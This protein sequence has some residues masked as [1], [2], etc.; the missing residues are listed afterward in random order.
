M[1]KTAFFY[2]LFFTLCQSLFAQAPNWTV[3]E[4]D[5]QYTMT[6]VAKLNADGKQ[7]IT[8]NDKVAAFVGNTCR[9]VSGVTYVAN[10]KNYYAFLTVFSNQQ[11]ETISFKL[12]DSAG[13]K[14]KSVTKTIP[15]VVNEHRGN[16]FQS[17][18]IAEPAL[19]NQS[20]ILSFNFL[21][22]TSL[23]SIISS[24]NVNI[25]IS[26]SYPLNN[27]KPVFTLSKGANLYKNKVLQKSGE[28]TDN[29]LAAITYEVLSE[30]ESNLKSYKVNVGQQA[31]P[32][33]FYKKDAVCY[34][35]GAIKVVS[36]KEGATVQVSSNGKT[37]A[38]KQI[39][40]GEAQFSDLNAG[41]YIATL[42]NDFKVINITIKYN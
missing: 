20:E 3:K 37:V 39:V 8:A 40:N 9:G 35:R 11:G 24:G 42:G 14:T 34:A 41:S 23:S 2:F 31:D 19:N 29:F 5:Y 4:N 13:D 21:D 26:E 1:K 7:L 10:E 6:F 32:T 17:Y 36:K 15:F 18:S 16:L 28:V 38:T 22:M 27:L 25:N 30:D 33:L 12:Y